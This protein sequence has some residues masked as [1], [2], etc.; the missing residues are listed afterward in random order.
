M[1][2]TEASPVCAMTPVDGLHKPGSVGPAVPG[3]DMKIIDNSANALKTG[4]T[5]EI[6]FRGKNIMLGYL[7]NPEATGRAVIDGWLHTGDIG[8]MD[9]DGYIYIK[10][11]SK[12]VIIVRGFNVYPHEVEEVIRSVPDVA[13][14]VVIGITDKL[15]GEIPAA[16]IIPVPGKQIDP[17]AVQKACRQKLAAYKIPRR[18]EFRTEFPR[19]ATNKVDRGALKADLTGISCNE[20]SSRKRQAV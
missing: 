6:C 10:G 19:L 15:S 12:E 3:V 8:Y 20:I 7:N 9:E 5:G 2:M 18:I 11:R 16:V 13:D 14:A 4:E 17:G 1:G